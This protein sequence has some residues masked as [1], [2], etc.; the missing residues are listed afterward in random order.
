VN[1]VLAV[2]DEPRFASFLAKGL[3]ASGFAPTVVDDGERASLIARDD[4]FDLVLLD[5]GLPRK[6][7]FAVLADIR[8]LGQRLPVIMLTMRDD[9]ADKVHGLTHGADDYITKPFEMAELLARIEAKL[10]RA[11]AGVHP[12]EGYQF[13]DIRVDFR[14]A[15]ILKAGA[16]VDLSAREFQ[17]LRYFIEHR[18]ATITREA[19]LNDVWGYSAIP[20]TRTVDVHVAW[21]RQKIE[22]NPRHPQFIVTIHGHGYKFAG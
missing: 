5:V 15:E 11:P 8:R 18:G 4:N 20:S 1:R 9:L 14:R 13:G 10:R 19:L 12:A 7:G 17:L 2:E 6:D 21:L 3:R 22:P 16:P